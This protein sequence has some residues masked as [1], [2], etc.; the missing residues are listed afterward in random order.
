MK[1]MEPVAR[2]AARATT[3]EGEPAHQR[4]ERNPLEADGAARLG[5]LE[6]GRAGA[7]V[8]CQGQGPRP[9]RRLTAGR[10]FCGV[11]LQKA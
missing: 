9:L 4:A 8:H 10:A 2:S 6:G 5:R 7:G 3:A 11:F 1:K